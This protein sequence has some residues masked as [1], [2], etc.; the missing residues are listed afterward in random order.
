M[1]TIGTNSAKILKRVCQNVPAFCC[2]MVDNMTM[3][4]GYGRMRDQIMVEKRW[5]VIDSTLGQDHYMVEPTQK[6][7]ESLRT[8]VQI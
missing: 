8:F 7:C 6:S 1:R 5:Q 4:S 2:V 3:R